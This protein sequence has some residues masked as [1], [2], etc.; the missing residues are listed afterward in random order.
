M[1]N[2]DFGYGQQ[3]PYDTTHELNVIAFIVRQ[4][5]A[6]MSTT[7]LV[8]VVA[9]HGGGLAPAGTVDV[10]QLVMLVDGNNNAS[11]H[12]TVYGLPWSRIQGGKNAI[13]CD[14]AVNDIGYV[15]ASDRDISKVKSTL[16]QAAPGSNRKFDIADGI[17]AGGCL[18]VA[19]NQYLIFT[20]AGVRLVDANGNSIAMTSAG[21]TITDANGNV[22]QMASGGIAITGNV[23]VTGTLTATKLETGEDGLT[24]TGPITATGEITAKFGGSSVTVTGHVHDQAVDSAGD[25]EQPT[26]SP[27]PGT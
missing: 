25:V 19:P 6:K 26:N 16:A 20:S 5:T 23:T 21:T 24:V 13:I 7:K 15:V 9:V 14:P 2:Q 18:N 10:L 1:S 11:A 27:T 8:Q 17:Y 3:T 4:M 12:K 22:I